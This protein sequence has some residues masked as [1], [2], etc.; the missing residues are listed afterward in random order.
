MENTRQYMR[1]HADLPVIATDKAGFFV[2]GQ[3]IDITIRGCGL[4]L[5]TPLRVGQLVMLMISS[6]NGTAAVECDLAQVQWVTKERAGVTFLRM[7]PD[8]ERRLHQLWD[9][10][11]ASEVWD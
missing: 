4:R 2:C 6:N 11:L 3:V 8:N 7:S 5:T 10:Q 9:D 1:A